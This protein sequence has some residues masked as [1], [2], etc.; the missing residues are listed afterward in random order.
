LRGS[1]RIFA[2][3]SFSADDLSGY[4]DLP[5]RVSGG[6]LESLP[7]DMKLVAQRRRRDRRGGAQWHGA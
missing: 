6:E 4:L 5:R 2:G 1:K 3:V 7:V